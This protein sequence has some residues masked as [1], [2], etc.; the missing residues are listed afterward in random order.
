[1]AVGK[2]YLQYAKSS[3]MQYVRS[4]G[5]VERCELTDKTEATIQYLQYLVTN[6]YT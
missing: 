1:M 2:C 6:V 5:T 4:Y 3:G